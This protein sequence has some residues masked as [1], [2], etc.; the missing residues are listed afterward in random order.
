MI[1]ETI[2]NELRKARKNRNEVA[3]N[4]LS[5]VLG[6]IQTALTRKDLEEDD[7]L[8]IIK[9]IIKSNNT[10][11]KSAGQ[12]YAE[13]AVTLKK[14]N[15]ILEAFLP[16]KLSVDQIVGI[17]KADFVESE[18]NFGKFMGMVIKNLKEKGLEFDAT[19]VKAAIIKLN[20]DN[21]LS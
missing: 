19:S 5:L 10:S 15:E 8:A 13:M 1:E 16:Q 11:L 21:E 18:P 4:I 6:E 7:K 12:E 17:I 3:I 20:K 14:E 9:K 2:K